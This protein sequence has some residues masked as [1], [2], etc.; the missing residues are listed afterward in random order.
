MANRKRGTL[1]PKV[2]DALAMTIWENPKHPGFAVL[3]KG[4]FA[5]DPHH[6]NLYKGQLR[7]AGAVAGEQV[8]KML[9]GR[10]HRMAKND[11]FRVHVRIS[12][13]KKEF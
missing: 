7:F 5:T 8:T 10:L 4:F 13:P 3:M 9:S 2:Y 6:C 11:D 1:L 12:A